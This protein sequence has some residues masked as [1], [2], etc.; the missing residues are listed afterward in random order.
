MVHNI[1]LY[2]FCVIML[3]L[4]I[5]YLIL[6]WSHHKNHSS[7]Y[8]IFNLVFTI[9]LLLDM[10][11]RLIPVSRG[12]GINSEQISF[13]CHTQ[14]FLLT[15]FD[16]NTIILITDFSIISCVDKFKLDLKEKEEKKIKLLFFSIVFCLIYTIILFILVKRTDRS[17]YCYVE[18]KS[19]IK[20]WIDF[21]VTSLL[22][23]I[24]SVCTLIIVF[25]WKNNDN[26]NN[27]KKKYDL[28]LFYLSLLLNLTTLS[29]VIWLI[30]RIFNFESDKKDI[31]DISYIIL[32]LIVNM[33]F[34]C[35]SE[36]WQYLQKICREK[37]H[38]CEDKNSDNNEEKIIN[39]TD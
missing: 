28:I 15:L 21:V 32:C 34:V 17:E 3:I 38:C 30:L 16:K 1:P 22:Y 13:W 26:I 19:H 35:N 14:A 24:N 27:C 2:V 29:Y 12:D 20:I 31:K 23:I 9:N 7:N 6:Y 37:C 18:T 5:F 25:R 10:I 39:E 33:L 8:F 36:F 11:V 4:I